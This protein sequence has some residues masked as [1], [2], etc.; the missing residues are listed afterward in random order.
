MY[1][2]FLPIIHLHVTIYIS[3]HPP[4]RLY[5]KAVQEIFKI[6]MIGFNIYFHIKKDKTD[7]IA[8]GTRGLS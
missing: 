1:S 3:I 2:Y 4:N 7:S 5:L 8:K 6:K